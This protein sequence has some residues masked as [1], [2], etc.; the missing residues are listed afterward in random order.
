MRSNEKPWIPTLSWNFHLERCN[1]FQDVFKKASGSRLFSG[2][3]FT[4]DILA[5]E[6]SSF[7]DKAMGDDSDGSIHSF[8]AV[9]NLKSD[10]Y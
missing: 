3:C 7:L 4:D 9:S 5:R 6:I 1:R 10:G 2:Y 8:D